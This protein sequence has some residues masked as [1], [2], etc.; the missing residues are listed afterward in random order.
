MN[1][2][3]RQQKNLNLRIVTGASAGAINGLISVLSMCKPATPVITETLN[4]KMWTEL[5]IDQLADPE[6]VS[7]TALFN[8][9]G[10]KAC[11]DQIRQD[12]MKGLS[13][14]C[15]LVLGIAVTRKQPV[16]IKVRPGLSYSRHHEFFVIRIQGQGLG[17]APRL[18]NFPLNE[19][20]GHQLYLPFNQK[21]FDDYSL[22]ESVFTASAQFPLAF[23]SAMLTY[24]DF[25]STKPAQA[26]TSDR[27]QTA[28]FID[29]GIFDNT[30][31]YLAYRI[32]NALLPAVE[33]KKTIFAVLTLGDQGI[34]QAPEPQQETK[35]FLDY[36][37]S[38]LSDFVS[39]SRNDGISQFF[40]RDPEIL[41]RTYSNQPILLKSSRYY[42]AFSGF[43]D[44]GFRHYDFYAG[45]FD[46][47]Y[48]LE[49]SFLGRKQDYASVKDS[50]TWQPFFCL[51]D[52]Y[53]K[54]DVSAA[55]CVRSLNQSTFRRL[56]K[57][58]LEMAIRNCV[59]SSPAEEY[60]LCNLLDMKTLRADIEKEMKQPKTSKVLSFLQ[61]Q[62]NESDLDFFSRRLSE[63]DYEFE[64]K[65]FPNEKLE[66]IMRRK[67]QPSIRRLL[68]SGENGSLLGEN[69]ANA[70]LNRL[71]YAPVNQ[72]NL[73]GVGSHLQYSY[74]H[75]LNESGSRPWSV[76]GFGVMATGLS[77]YLTSEEDIASL[78]PF[79]AYKMIWTSSSDFWY[80]P[81][82]GVRIGYNHPLQSHHEICSSNRKFVPAYACPDWFTQ[83][84]IGVSLL[85]MLSFEVGLKIYGRDNSNQEATFLVQFQLISLD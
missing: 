49:D 18:S 14:D 43:V 80:Q 31:V 36:T 33:R 64:H 51:H 83:P 69:E 23:P 73:F 40:H 56:A 44:R 59:R 66:S 46:A 52:I 10:L 39:T 37:A 26:C 45:M 74:N 7:S 34:P 47:N 5:G 19:K 17:K 27:V 3:L 1:H 53:M 76:I 38:L 13:E 68:S 58:N 21:G 6:K 30:P 65:S 85:D 78:G 29:G 63:L 28:E 82:I 48:F 62:G 15:D 84:L 24:C 16:A 32:S 61:D 9:V 42:Y 20:D 25:E 4:W 41:K 79:A 35:S 8:R 12:F 57:V 54:Q 50:E 71:S 22:L 2:Q 81:E 70:I 11:T 75:L 55:S 67:L 60:E 77:S 72:K